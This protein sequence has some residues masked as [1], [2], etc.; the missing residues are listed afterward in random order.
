M[1]RKAKRESGNKGVP[2]T[3]RAETKAQKERWE[4]AAAREGRTLNDWI[5]R[6]LDVT[7][8]GGKT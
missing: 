8:A 1:T 4:A 6:T 5:R 3:L 7:A 2:V